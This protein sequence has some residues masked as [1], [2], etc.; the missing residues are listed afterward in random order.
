MKKLNLFALGFIIT[1]SLLVIS[2]CRKKQDT[3]AK[4][5]V[6]DSDNN[7]VTSCRV[8]LFPDPTEGSGAGKTLIK[9]DTAIT[10]SSGEAI[11]NYNYLYQ[12]GQAGVAVLDIHAF[13]DG[14]TGTGV[15]QIKE[16]QTTITTVTI[17]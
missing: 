13:K 7:P 17:N 1:A 16:E 9:A 15:I 11:F 10:N 2:S 4:V 8:I 3:I 5:F 12:L 6:K 14:Y